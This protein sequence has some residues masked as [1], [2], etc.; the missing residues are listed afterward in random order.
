MKKGTLLKRWIAVL[1]AMILTVS[2]FAIPAFAE[3]TESSTESTEESSSEATTESDTD[4]D[5]E[6]ESESESGSEE[7]STSESEE[8]S[9]SEEEEE[10][11]GAD[12]DENDGNGLSTN[13]I[14][15]I[16]VGAVVVVVGAVLCI[17]FREKLKKS[18]RVYKSESK[19]IVWLPWDQTKKNTIV[20]IIILAVCA[21]AIWVVDYL[22]SQG[23]LAFINLF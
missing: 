20:V 9:S 13:M 19:K 5:T 23:I 3:T 21:V 1:C 17:K 18:W 15:W 12:G 14:V 11:T 6:S 4:A 10:S 22:L 8:D 2:L 16:I 7:D